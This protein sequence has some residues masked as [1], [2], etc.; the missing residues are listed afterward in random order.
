MFRADL[1][2]IIRGLNTVFTGIDICHVSYVDSL[3]A[4]SEF[5]TKINLRNSASR[6]FYYK[7]M[8]EMYNENLILRPL[9][10]CEIIDCTSIKL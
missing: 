6:W 10:T 3:P 9:F 5:F 2:S 7:N 1:L 4:R 8:T